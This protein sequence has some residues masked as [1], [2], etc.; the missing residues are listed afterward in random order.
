MLRTATSGPLAGD[1]GGSSHS[2]S[3]TITSGNISGAAIPSTSNAA[4]SQDGATFVGSSHASGSAVAGLTNILSQSV[5]A[6]VG[7][8]PVY[9]SANN[10]GNLRKV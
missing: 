6:T 10:I 7:G 1:Q 2:G 8:M 9:I 4:I 3:T 5:A